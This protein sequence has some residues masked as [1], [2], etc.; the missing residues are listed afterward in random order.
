MPSDAAYL[1]IRYRL[2]P[3]PLQSMRSDA[4]YLR[5]RYRLLPSPLQSMR[6]DAACLRVRYRLPPSPLQSMPSDAAY[7]RIRYRLPPGAGGRQTPRSGSWLGY[8]VRDSR[9]E[10]AMRAMSSSEATM[11]GARRIVD[12]CVSLART[13]RS[14]MR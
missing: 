12:P 14:A 1:R 7:L 5:I 10:L 6:S 2:L 3:S 11:G 13:P 9:M 8:A 4:A